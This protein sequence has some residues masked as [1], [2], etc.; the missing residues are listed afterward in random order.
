MLSTTLAHLYFAYL[1]REGL[2]PL[3]A[4]CDHMW[5]R[6][7]VMSLVRGVPR[8][9][10]DFVFRRD[11][12]VVGESLRKVMDLSPSSSVGAFFRGEEGQGDGVTRGWYQLVCKALTHG[13]Q[14][15]ADGWLD[16]FVR[17]EGWQLA[18]E[19]DHWPL[20]YAPGAP[21]FWAPMD[22]VTAGET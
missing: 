17:S 11:S 4:V 12:N 21:G 3:S 10:H 8:F 5:R 15:P 6:D 2:S 18:Q 14:R 7:V 16:A 19:A 9:R 1:Q 22:Y 20:F 13:D